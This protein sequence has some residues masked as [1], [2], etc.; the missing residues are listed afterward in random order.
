M[1]A[2]AADRVTKSKGKLRR[3]RYPMGDDII[4]AGG[5]V[6]INQSG[7]AVAASDTAGL[8]DVVGVSVATFDNAGGANGAIDCIVEY[9]GA[10]LVDA[11]ASLTQ[12]DVGRDAYVSDDQTLADYAAATNK[13]RAGRVLEFVDETQDKVWVNIDNGRGLN[14][15][16]DGIIAENIDLFMSTEQTGTGSPQNV[17]HGLGAAPSVVFVSFTEFNGDDGAHDI[18]EGTHTATNIVLTVTSG[19]KFKVLAIR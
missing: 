7:Y 11:A 8:S 17:A 6:C 5:M 12:V 18:A 14:A 4:Y 16:V 1:A 3:Q 13:I 2:L 19:A 9:G 15:A 10:F